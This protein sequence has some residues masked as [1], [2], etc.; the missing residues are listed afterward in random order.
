MMTL[1]RVMLAG[2]LT[3]DPELRRTPN[4]AAVAV[5]GLAAN[6]RFATRQG[7]QREEVCFVDIEI[8]GKQA[9]A[10]CQYLSKGAPAFV[11]G[12]LRCDR[13]EDK[14]TGQRRSRLLVRADRVQFLQ[15]GRVAGRTGEDGGRGGRGQEERVYEAGG[16]SDQRRVA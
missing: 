1:N 10:C 15:G 2:N 3:R 7:E 8:W 16:R 12:R 6:E 11:E 14:Q 4:G 5:F 9:E 13:W